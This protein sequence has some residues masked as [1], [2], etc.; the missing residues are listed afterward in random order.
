MPATRLDGRPFVR[1]WAATILPLL[2]IG[3]LLPVLPLY[4]RGPLEAGGLGVG[5]TV[6][7]ASPAAFL[8]QP[9]AGRLGDRRGRRLLVVGG[10]LLAAG[11][12]AAYTTADSLALLVAFRLATG[13]GEA[14]VF[15]GTATVVNDLAP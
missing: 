6:A 11:A 10:G 14:L 3:M 13:V 15:V 8:F 1:P 12:V 9:L 5:L 4:A 2:A 7:A